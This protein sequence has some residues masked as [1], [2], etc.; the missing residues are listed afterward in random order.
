MRPAGEVLHTTQH[1]LR[2]KT[3]LSRHGFP[4]TRFEAIREEA[5]LCRA[6][7]DFGPAILKTAGFGYDGKGQYRV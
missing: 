1:R 7:P 2:E 5:D 3:F 4:V 6:V